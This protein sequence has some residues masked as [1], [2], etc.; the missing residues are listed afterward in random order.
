MVAI[1]FLLQ[2]LVG[3]SF[4]EEEVC[5]QP[6]FEGT[7]PSYIYSIIPAR[8]VKLSPACY[9]QGGGISIQ[10]NGAFAEIDRTIPH[11]ES[12]EN[13]F[14]LWINDTKI[15]NDTQEIKAEYGF[16]R[17]IDEDGN[18]TPVAMY[19]V[20]WMPELKKGPQQV[21]ILI[22]QDNGEILA[23]SWEFEITN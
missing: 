7:G 15:S 4:F 18:K 13:R 3:C 14:E 8:D 16:L 17:V 10:V 1:L 6:P 12:L 5:D 21:E 11:Q 20:S 9:R 23:Y 19:A 22:I 2:F